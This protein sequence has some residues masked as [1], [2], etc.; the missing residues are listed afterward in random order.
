MPF[1]MEGGGVVMWRLVTVALAAM[2]G[3]PG[4]FAA[5]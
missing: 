5:D 1:V 3:A 2:L 4:V